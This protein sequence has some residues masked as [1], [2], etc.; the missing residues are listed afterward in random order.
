MSTQIFHYNHSF[1]LENGIQLA[2][3]CVGQVIGGQRNAIFQLERMIIMKYL[4]GHVLFK[5]S[6]LLIKNNCS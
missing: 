5:F 1:N 6:G 2:I 4:R 3:S